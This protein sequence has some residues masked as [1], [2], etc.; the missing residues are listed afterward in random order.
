MRQ[1]LYDLWACLCVCSFGPVQEYKFSR[2]A[3]I[4]RFLCGGLRAIGRP[5][6]SAISFVVRMVYGPSLSAL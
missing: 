2:V 5:A 4:V 6:L 1:A 3:P